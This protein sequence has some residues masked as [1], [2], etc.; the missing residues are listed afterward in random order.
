MFRHPLHKVE[1][2]PQQFRLMHQFFFAQNRELPHFFNNGPD[3]AHRF[4]NIA[5]A[6]FT[7]GPDH[8]RAFRNAPQRL[9][10][11]ARA[12]HKRR[13]EITLID[14]M[15]FIGRGEHLAFVNV[16]HAQSFQNARFTEVPD[17]G[18]RHHRDRDGTHNFPD[19][20]DRRHTRHAT[21]F[22][23]IGRHPFQR[24]HGHCPGPF[25]DH[26]LFGVDHV[27]DDAAFEHFRQPD[28]EPKLFVIQNHFIGFSTKAFFTATIT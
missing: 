26:R 21:L 14:V 8:A 9:A 15:L 19:H 11:V 2:C 7:L 28:I 12:A 25:R 1:R 27:H 24:H 22:T 4:H 10:Q 6:R 3:V 18:L 20:A 13:F 23:D 17:A 5:G 16:I